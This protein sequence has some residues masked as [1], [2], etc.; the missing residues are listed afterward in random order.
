MDRFLLL[1][2]SPILFIVFCLANSTYDEETLVGIVG[3]WIVLY[4]YFFPWLVSWCRRHNN[5][6]AIFVMN[7]FLGW[8]LVGWIAALIWGVFRRSL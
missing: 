5:S 3:I 2:A 8:T 4:A 7:L 1:L 6:L